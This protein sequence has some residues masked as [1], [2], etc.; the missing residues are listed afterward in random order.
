MLAMSVAMLA[1]LWANLW[2][3]PKYQQKYPLNKAYKDISAYKK[4]PNAKT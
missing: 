3:N 2:G 4:Q 1:V